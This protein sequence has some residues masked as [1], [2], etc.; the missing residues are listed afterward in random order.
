MRYLASAGSRSVMLKA[1][2][3]EWSKRFDFDAPMAE[4]P[5]AGLEQTKPR[6][7]PVRM[8]HPTLG[9]KTVNES[10]D[11][12]QLVR[13]GWVP[14]Q[15]DPANF[16]EGVHIQQYYFQSRWFPRLRW[17]TLRPPMGS[18]S[19]SATVRLVGVRLSV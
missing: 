19:S 12:D 15:D 8:I 11:I 17:F 9:T 13:S 3:L 2:E 16:L 1:L 4:T 10:S 18:S 7:R 6:E 14:D 5:P